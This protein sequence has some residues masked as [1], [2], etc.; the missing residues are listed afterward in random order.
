MRKHIL[1]VILFSLVLSMAACTS[2]KEPVIVEDTFEIYLATTE[3]VRNY[4]YYDTKKLILNSIPV[5]TGDDIRYYYWEQHNIEL[6]GSFLGKLQDADLSSY[7]YY[8]SG[9]DG[10]RHYA[11]GGSKFLY[12]GQYMCFII[13]ING[14]KVYS[15]TFPAGPN[16]PEE[17]EMLVMGDISDEKIEIRYNGDEFDIRNNDKVYDYFL[18]SGKL[19]KMSSEDSEELVNNLQTR[20]DESENQYKE[21]MQLY[22]EM[23]AGMG[24]GADSDSRESII[25]WLNNRIILYTIE[26]QEGETHREFSNSLL[27]L[28]LSQIDSIGIAADIFRQKA[29]SSANKN[30][31][32][33]NVFEELYYVVIEGIPI[34]N[35]IDEIDEEFIKSAEDNWITIVTDK[36]EISAYPTPGKLR[37]N[38]GI[39]LSPEINEYL[40]LIDLE[41]GMMS[42]AGTTE[43]TSDK[44]LELSLDDL[45]D[46]IYIWKKYTKDFPYSYPFIYK[47]KDRAEFLLDIYLGKT[48]FN[49]SPVFNQETM[50]ITD[51]AKESYERFII[52]YPDSPFYNLVSDYYNLLKLSA[53][54]YS[55]EVDEFV[56]KINY[57]DYR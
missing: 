29:V 54:L 15:G 20:L 26:T 33:F 39:F 30:D 34:F 32:M 13:V 37:E 1:T 8:E 45:A 11:T 57:D 3:S 43:I 27:E 19:G 52:D 46:L 40:L 2:E 9:D 22:D 23:A 50:I 56:N 47:A 7:N 49:E 17:D 14:E 55:Q 6:N 12:S 35:R 38:F 44:K 28:D 18:N 51:E 48:T 24:A 5:I 53:F 16:L 31:R 42:S 25:K 4:G 10:F 41:R 21:L 36:G